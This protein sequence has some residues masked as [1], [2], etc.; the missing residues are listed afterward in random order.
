MKAIAKN[1]RI[2][3]K[4]MRVIAEIVRGMEAGKAL[5]ILKFMPK[6]GAS[7][8]YKIVASAAA[9]A[10]HNDSQAAGELKVARITVDRGIVYKRG[11]PISRGRN[12][13]IIKPTCVISVHLSK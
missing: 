8:L 5:D 2:A 13:S 11:Q 7:I 1:I 4:K 9:N 10:A 3:P 6:K 12:H